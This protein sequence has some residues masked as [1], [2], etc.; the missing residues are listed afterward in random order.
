MSKVKITIG[1]LNISSKAKRY[2]NEVLSS[3]RLSYGPFTKKFESLFASMHGIPYAI[4]SNS[5]T[6]ALH[7]ALAALKE[8]YKWKDNDE[9]IVPA[10]TFVATSNVVLYNKL[11]P[12]FVDVDPL[13]YEIESEKILKKIT[14]RTRAIIPVH[15]FGQPADMKPIMEIARIKGLRVIED[16]AETM[17]ARYRGKYV[18][19]FGDIGC[20][21]TY[22]AHL[23][24]T[25]VGG[26]NTT[27]DPE[28]ALVLRSLINHGRDPIYL[29]IDDDDVSR[30]KL[31]RIIEK[32]F[33]FIRLG[34]S[35]RITEMESAIGVAQL[36]NELEWNIEKRR[37]NAKI[38]N[39]LLKDLEHLI[40]LPKVRSGNEHSFMMYPIILKKRNKKELVQYLE[41]NGIETR[42]LFPLI[43]Q[44]IY[45]KL[46]K[47]SAKDFSV[48]HWLIRSGFYIGCHQDL[49]RKDLEYISSTIHTFFEK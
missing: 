28:L 1:N 9:I 33:S 2:V 41:N 6:S 37:K 42:E 48:S 36:E 12:V 25:G 23:L 44:P 38:L 14:K 19:S 34:H 18:G 21:S 4:A 11:K 24:T 40:Q 26:F 20:F 49:T 10:T 15:L 3:N 35:F 30:K 16:S 32:R 27:K 47:L 22:V 5:G 29:S 39:E 13:Y 7:V 45:K 43:N 31:S 17:L 8:V 46:F